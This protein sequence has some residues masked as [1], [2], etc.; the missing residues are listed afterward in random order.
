MK[1]LLASLLGFFLFAGCGTPQPDIG[2]EWQGLLP[3]AGGLSGS[4]FTSYSIDL[5]LEK[6]GDTR[7]KAS[8]EFLVARSTPVS[9]TDSMSRSMSLSGELHKDSTITLEGAMNQPNRPDRPV[10]LDLVLNE[11]GDLEGRM[12]SGDISDEVHLQRQEK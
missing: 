2:G 4:S 11:E 3:E 6:S 5:D 8:G 12:D 10:T 9:G 7:Y 1:R